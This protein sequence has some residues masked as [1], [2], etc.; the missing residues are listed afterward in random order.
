MKLK[1]ELVA[2]SSFY[3]CFL[4]CIKDTKSLIEILDN[5]KAHIP[6]KVSEEIRN[7]PNWRR[8][9]NHKN[10]NHFS[11]PPFDI[12]KLIQPF[13]SKQEIKKG[14]YDIILTAYFIFNLSKEKDFVLVIDDKKPRNFVQKNFLDLAHYLRGTVNF[15]RD[16]YVNYKIFNKNEVLVLYDNIEKS[17]FRV[18]LNILTNLREE[19]CQK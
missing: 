17:N 3:I 7:S 2:D 9:S 4:D 19:I 18:K 11:N 8:I 5:F 16:C 6:P 15:I 1:R 12:G 10:L 14:E 13:L